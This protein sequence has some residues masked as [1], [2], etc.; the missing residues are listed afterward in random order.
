MGGVAVVVVVAAAAHRP[1]H[2][3]KTVTVAHAIAFQILRALA[4]LW[5]P[6]M[7]SHALG[8]LDP[9]WLA[10][11]IIHTSIKHA[12]AVQRSTVARS[13]MYPWEGGQT[14]SGCSWRQHCVNE[15]WMYWCGLSMEAGAPGLMVAPPTAL[16]VEAGRRRLSLKMTWPAIPLR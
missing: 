9:L 12:T 3:P 11:Q 14:C 5:T 2:R 15:L 1:A 6:L 13:G 10:A 7:C 4:S 8:K 16:A